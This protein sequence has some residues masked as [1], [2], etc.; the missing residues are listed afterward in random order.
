[1]SGHAARSDLGRLGE[2]LAREHLECLGYTV[3]A[4]N[5]ATRWGELDLIACDGLTLVFCEVKT[6]RSGGG[7]PW[8]ALGPPKQRRVRRMA[9]GWLRA[10]SDRPHLPNL[11]FDAIGVVINGRGELVALDHVEGAF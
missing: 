6:R 5:Y 1:M 3:L 10:T 8:E 11:R 9:A 7:S 2:R 4:R